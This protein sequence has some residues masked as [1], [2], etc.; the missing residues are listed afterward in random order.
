M[1]IFPTTFSKPQ[2]VKKTISPA[3]DEAIDFLNERGLTVLVGVD[4]E[5]AAAISKMANEQHI[6]EYCPNDCSKRFADLEA[7]RGWLSHR[8]AVF[9]LAKKNEDGSWRAVGYGWSGPKK[10]DEVP[11][12]ET[13]FALRI[14]KAGLGQHL[15]EPFSQVVLAATAKLY[16]AKN[17]W[18]ETW[19]SNAAAV[20]VYKKL[21]FKLVNQKPGKRPT[22]DSQQVDDTRL[23]MFLP[24]N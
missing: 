16:D 2:A 11:G 23:Y 19:A 14:G 1:S 12:G 7:T 24:S 3:A 13:T 15:S 8:H 22:A 9:T 4:E 17:F 21:G 10:V 6:R 20:H 5:L 18:L